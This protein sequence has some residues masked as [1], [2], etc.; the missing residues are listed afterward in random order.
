MRLS[1]SF[2]L[3]LALLI[4]LHACRTLKELRAFTKCEFRID[5]IQQLN[6]GGVNLLNINDFSDLNVSDVAKVGLAFKNGSL[7]LNITFNIEIKNPNEQ[8]AALEKLD[9]IIEVDE[10]DYVN[11]T[12]N[13][14][15]EI[16]PNGGVNDLNLST[17]LDVR[18]AL[19]GES[20]QSLVNLVAG[21]KGNNQEDAR[22]RLKI[23]P[24]FKFLGTTVGYPGYLKLTKEFKSS[25]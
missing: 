10:N 9:W 1:K 25:E 19:Q 4:S 23:K 17:A 11:G 5:Q 24:R 7:P 3:L 6:L 2:L 21:I 20:V 13:E 16:A 18:K 15:T 12:S 14:R 8:T 22:L